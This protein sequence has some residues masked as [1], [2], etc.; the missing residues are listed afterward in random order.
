MKHL[1][2]F[3]VILSSLGI[4][5]NGCAL[6]TV[7][8]SF[9]YELPSFN[10]ALQGIN[11]E[12]ARYGVKAEVRVHSIYSDMYN[13]LR[14]GVVNSALKQINEQIP[15]AQAQSGHYA[16][17][18][19]ITD[20]HNV[21]RVWVSRD[22][23]GSVTG[24]DE[25]KRGLEVLVIR[26]DVIKILPS[27]GKTSEFGIEITPAKGFYPWTEAGKKLFAKHLAP[28]LQDHSMSDANSTIEIALQSKHQ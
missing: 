26:A 1:V 21:R 27:H 20:I 2:A 15:A 19:V 25:K 8:G 18:N 24:R 5:F 12:Y 22:L 4:L 11:F 17:V 6:P 7:G 23:G 13:D 10:V 14:L 16:L 3:M 28:L 9:T